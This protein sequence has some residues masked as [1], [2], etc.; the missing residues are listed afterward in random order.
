[1]IKAPTAT[2]VSAS[3]STFTSTPGPTLT[4]EQDCANLAVQG[5]HGLYLMYLEPSEA[6]VW[7]N[8]PRE[9]RAGVC[10]SLP[11]PLVPESKFKVMVY[12]FGVSR[13]MGQTSELSAQLGPGLHDVILR[14]WTPGLVNHMTICVQR[15]AVELELG[16]KDDPTRSFH[17]VQWLDGRERLTLPVKCGGTFA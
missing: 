16:Y 4:P 12:I 3:T 1:M 10:N 11:V 17:P 14:L 2:N 9:F 13:P 8:I 7:D 15:Q 5:Q 6:L